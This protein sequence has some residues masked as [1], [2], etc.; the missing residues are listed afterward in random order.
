MALRGPR[1]IFP[2]QVAEPIRLVTCSYNPQAAS[3]LTR[4]LTILAVLSTVN[5]MG[6]QGTKMKADKFQDPN[7]AV[8]TQKLERMQAWHWHAGQGALSNAATGVSIVA[9][10]TIFN[11]HYLQQVY[12]PPQELQ[13]RG[14]A[15]RFYKK[16]HF[17]I[18][19]MC[20]YLPA[21]GEPSQRQECTDRLLAWAHHVLEQH[22]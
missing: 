2:K 7:S 10:R 8:H 12:S 11:Q 15:L 22:R 21:G 9:D 16:D 14:G 1:P 3:S 5:L 17:D 19:P 4:W 13:G 18:L 20:L 6:C